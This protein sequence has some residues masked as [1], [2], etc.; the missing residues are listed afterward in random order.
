MSE[1]SDRASRFQLRATVRSAIHEM[2]LIV[3]G[4]LLR[5]SSGIF[6]RLLTFPC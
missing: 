4:K 3:E 6:A 1:Q 2:R 5:L